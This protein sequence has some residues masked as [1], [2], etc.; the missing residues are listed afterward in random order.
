MVRKGLTIIVM[1]LIATIWS[2][3]SF[4]SAQDA[5]PLVKG[6]GKN[7]Y[8]LLEGKWVRPDGGYVLQLRNVESSGE[9]KASYYNP[10]SINVGTS[11]WKVD[12]KNLTVFIELRDINYQGSTY[13]LKYDPDSGRLKGKYFQAPTGRTYDVEFVRVQWGEESVIGHRCS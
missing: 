12:D 7:Q 9:L 13:T 4:V 5:K 8:Q 1:L 10:K 3:A 6:G 11:N 2:G